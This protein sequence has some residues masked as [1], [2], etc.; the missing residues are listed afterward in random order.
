MATTAIASAR[1]ENIPVLI[2][3]MQEYYA[4]DGV[5]FEQDN[6]VLALTTLL[7]NEGFGRVWLVWQ[8]DLPV[9]YVVITFGYS[10]EFGGRD[11]FIDELYIQKPYRG[12]GIGTTIL[13]RVESTLRAL[14]I[15]AL[16]LEVEGDNQRAQQFYAANGFEARQRFHLMSKRLQPVHQT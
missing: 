5:E 15:G 9:G 10:L 7:R 3:L 1:P 4:F 12:L 13:K 11:A 14:G 6:A 16:H 2:R 8:D